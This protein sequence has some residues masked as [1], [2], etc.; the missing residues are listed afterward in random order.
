MGFSV[1]VK[2]SV[3]SGGLGSARVRTRR[4][5]ISMILE[6]RRIR[7]YVERESWGSDRDKVVRGGGCNK[8]Q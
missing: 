8:V 4:S 2:T 5:E 1:L 3:I 7:T 6:G